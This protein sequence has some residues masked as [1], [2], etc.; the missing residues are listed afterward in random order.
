MYYEIPGSKLD[1]EHQVG[2]IRGGGGM[3][4]A[5]GQKRVHDDAN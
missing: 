3:T 1:S 5:M 2:K 4:R